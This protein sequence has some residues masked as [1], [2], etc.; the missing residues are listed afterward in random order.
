M[1]GNGSLPEPVKVLH[2]EPGV[3]TLRCRGIDLSI[4][5]F[6]GMSSS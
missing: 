1:V 2:G 6:T 4:V 5:L 3:K